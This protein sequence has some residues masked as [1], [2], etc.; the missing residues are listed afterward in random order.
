MHSVEK[1]TSSNILI[2]IF[3]LHFQLYLELESYPNYNRNRA[4][5]SFAVVKSQIERLT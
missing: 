4:I 2:E 1:K 3:F 5:G